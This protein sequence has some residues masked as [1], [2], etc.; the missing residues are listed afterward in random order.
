MKHP[1]M[2][3][4]LLFVAGAAGAG[5]APDDQGLF[6]GR[7]I[8]HPAV[9]VL[10]A[11]DSRV[12]I[13]GAG[14]ASSDYYGEIG[15]SASINNLPA[16]Y[17]L[18]GNAGYA[19]RYYSTYN[20]FDDDRY[21]LGIGAN[22]VQ[23]SLKWSMQTTLRKTLDYDTTARIQDGKT[24]GTI[25]SDETKHTYSLN[26][27]VS[28][29]GRLSDVTDLTPGYRGR[30]FYEKPE[31]SDDRK[32]QTHS[33][34]LQLG[35]R[36]SDITKATLTGTASYQIN[37]EEEGLVSQVMVGL[38][39]K[40]TENTQWEAGVGG[41]SANYGQSGSDQAF[42][43]NA[44]GLWQLSEGI[45]V[46][47][48]GGNYYQPGYGG[49]GASRVYR[50]GYGADWRFRNRWRAAVQ[51]LHSYNE[52]L[53]GSGT[54]NDGNARHFASLGVDYEF[55]NRLAIGVKG[56]YVRDYFEEDEIIISITASKRY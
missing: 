30:F 56:K 32:W 12:L 6:L 25:L 42:I 23:D 18:S 52:S 44:K 20:E 46:Y 3:A 35:Y 47:L 2:Y 48:F 39:S 22:S 7:W 11:Y 45:S 10:G 19:R 24:P 43:F 38:Q 15:A 29:E 49:G 54:A 33:A 17:S 26:A 28:Y 1:V 9:D 50:L 51:M 37:E 34:D 27:A 8:I 55:E 13:D 14:G 16:R 4:L 5:V 31:Q 36:Y 41:A 53:G 40:P 21:H